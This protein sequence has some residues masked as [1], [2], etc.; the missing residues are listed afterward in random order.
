MK[1]TKT[2]M[3]DFI[4]NNFTMKGKKIPK[5]T[6]N[7]YSKEALEGIIIKNNCQDR[8]TNWINKPKMIKFIVDGVQNGTYYSWDC[9][10]PS[11]DECRKA[12]EK[13]GIKVTKIATKSNHHRCKY[14]GTIAKGKIADLLCDDCREC[15]GHTYYSEL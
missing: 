1:A 6:L 10:Y 12:F 11:E 7:T 9:E 3:V 2:Q 5:K 15:F 14:C 4:Y 8:F 13:D